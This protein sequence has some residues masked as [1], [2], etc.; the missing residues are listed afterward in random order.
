MKKNANGIPP[1]VAILLTLVV[2]GL[3]VL[4]FVTKHYFWG[5]VFALI[6][7]DF[8]ADVILSFKKA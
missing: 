3:A 2:A 5:A 7:V 6:T 1:I 8:F 4:F